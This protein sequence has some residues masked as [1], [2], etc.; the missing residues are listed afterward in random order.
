MIIHYHCNCKQ[1]WVLVALS[2]DSTRQLHW[3]TLCDLEEVVVSLGHRSTSRVWLNRILV[4]HTQRDKDRATSQQYT[5]EAHT[6]TGTT[7][8][9]Q[10]HWLLHSFLFQKKKTKKNIFIRFVMYNTNPHHR[11]SGCGWSNESGANRGIANTCTQQFVG[12][13]NLWWVAG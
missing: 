6:V 4:R 5:H 1:Q 8:D 10:N 3:V 2:D 12:M 13:A 11:I 9:A 7:T